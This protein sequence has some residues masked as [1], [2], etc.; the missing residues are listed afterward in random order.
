MWLGMDNRELK[1]YGIPG[2]KWG[3]R[4]FIERHDKGKTHRDRLQNKYLE[5]GYSKEESSKRADD[6][7]RAEKAL[8]IAG[9]VALTAAVAFYAHHKY[10]TDEVISKNVKFQKIMLLPDD[11]RPSGNLNYM[12]FKKRDKKRYEGTYAQALLADKWRRGSN[13][14]V[15]KLTTQFNRD[16]KIASP[17]RARDT[18]KDLYK[19]DPEFRNLVSKVSN[20][21]NAETDSTKKQAK[22]YKALDSLVKGKNKNFHGKAYDGFNG[23][24]AGK[25]ETFDKIRSKYYEALKKQGVDA[26]IDRNDKA[27]SGYG[28][29]KPVIMLRQIG[30]RNNMREMSTNEILAK[31]LREELKAKGKKIVKYLAAPAA[32]YQVTKQATEEY[33]YQMKNRKKNKSKK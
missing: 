1:H 32:A 10:T 12:A 2:M 14:Q 19:K 27:L 33:N 7:I 30:A 25:G 23:T 15:K 17:K 11:I 31:G 8:A 26:V 29:K 16:I 18:F 21:A 6:R 4:K 5:R 24:L 22:A 13:E 20:I 3:V 9:G 28:T